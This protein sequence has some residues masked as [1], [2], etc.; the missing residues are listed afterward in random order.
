MTSRL[1][2]Q[3]T[4]RPNRIE[5]K[6]NASRDAG[7]RCRRQHPWGRQPQVLTES[8]GQRRADRLTPEHVEKAF[9]PL[10]VNGRASE[11]RP[12][13]RASRIKIRGVLGKA[14]EY[15][16]RRQLVTRNV[17][18][19]VELP[20]TARRGAPGRSLTVEQANHLLTSTADHQLHALWRLMLMTGLRPGE[21]TGLTW[22]DVDLDEG[23]VHIRRSLKLEQGTLHVT[24]TL[25]TTRL[26]RSLK[27]HLSVIEALRHH[28]APNRPEQP[29]TRLSHPDRKGRPR[30]LASA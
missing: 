22:A 5:G 13:S 29:P 19:V 4:C 11:G 30:P 7:E 16:V 21:A 2:A 6:A 1:A 8:I 28:R 23:L 18:R 3:T 27:A 24:D 10:A 12:V 20:S 17:A 9:A 15:G 26:R 25:K 14:L